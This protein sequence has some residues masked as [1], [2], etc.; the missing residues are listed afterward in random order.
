MRYGLF[1]VF[2]A[3]CASAGQPGADVDAGKND[4]SPDAPRDA[5][6]PDAQNVCPSTATCANAM[7]LGMVS[8]DTANQKLTMTGYQSAWFRVRVTEDDSGTIGLTLRV[9]SKLTSPNGVNFD[10][11]VY[12][13]SNSTAVE[14]NTTTGTVT[15][16]GALDQVRA[17]WGEPIIPNGVSDSRN[18]SIEIRPVSTNC[19]PG[20]QWQ[21]EVEGNWI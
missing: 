8:G 3:A 16:N 12:L 17:E 1:V 4:A 10:T 21:L 5:A 9:A 18:V 15:M 2:S 7:M 20:S 14:C 6:M 19:A 13:G 11:F